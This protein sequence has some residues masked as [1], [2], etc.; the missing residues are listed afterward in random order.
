MIR[1]SVGDQNFLRSGYN[2]Q[3]NI[4]TLVR[5][6][7]KETD[8]HTSI[9]YGVDTAEQ[10]SFKLINDLL[11]R[12]ILFIGINEDK[13][14]W[15]VSQKDI[16]TPTAIVEAKY[17]DSNGYSPDGSNFIKWEEV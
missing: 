15:C 10:P 5:T 4:D 7:F 3:L 11:S 6:G 1:Y 17:I 2:T 9:M 16:R 12:N 13:T 14:T 8:I